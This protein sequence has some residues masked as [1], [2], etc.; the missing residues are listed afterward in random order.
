MPLHVSCECGATLTVKDE[1]CGRAA[2][3]PRCER[4]V[5]VESAPPPPQSVA[6]RCP[7][8]QRRFTV[9]AR[10]IPELC[11]DCAARPRVPGTPREKQ[12]A[13]LTSPGASHCSEGTLHRRG[14]LW[15]IIAL[16]VGIGSILAV[17]ALIS[18]GRPS[19]NPAQSIANAKLEKALNRA[20]DSD[21]RNS[22]IDASAYYSGTFNTSVIVFDLQDI[23]GTKSRAD[24]FRLLLDF[25]YEIRD[26]DYQQFE[27]AFRGETKFKVD[28]FYFRSLGRDRHVE[29]PMYTIRT[30]PEHLET[31]TGLRAY[32]EW[33]G[34]A[35]GVLSKQ[36]D[37]FSDFHDRWYMNELLYRD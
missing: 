20:I 3:C 4:R 15:V 21:D 11:R 6:W 19:I 26:D 27:L 30:F 28:G 24:V 31:P 34:G 36:M 7:R 32:P 14:W 1:F 16:P 35:L 22:G 18:G 2:T 13:T 25:A 33:T 8:C 12:L 10:Q 29:N 23:D 37:D 9:L 5:I 17:F